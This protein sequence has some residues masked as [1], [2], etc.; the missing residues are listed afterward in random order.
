MTDWIKFDKYNK[1]TWPELHKDVLCHVI[2][3]RKSVIFIDKVTEPSDG[4]IWSG[5]S[6]HYDIHWMPLP[7]PP[8]LKHEGVCK[9]FNENYL[10]R[11][12]NED[13][14]FAFHYEDGNYYAGYSEALKYCPACGE[15]L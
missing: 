1:S 4:N 3:D 8:K 12:D 15:K 5:V 7:N 9:E 14:G 13:Y 2:E 6:L 11:G 10:T